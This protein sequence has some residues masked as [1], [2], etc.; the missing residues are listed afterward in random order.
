M[1]KKIAKKIIPK[2]FQEKIYKTL[3]KPFEN[4]A[5]EFYSQEGED[6]ILARFFD[7]SYK[8]FFVDIGAHHPKRFSNTYHFYKKGWRGINI[9]AMP[10]SMKLFNKLRPRDI[11]LE[12]AVS[13]KSQKLT[14]YAFKESALNGFSEE[15]SLLRNK[16]QNCELLFK[17]DLK[18]VALAKVLDQNLPKGQKI[19]F[20]TVDV[21]GLDLE[22]L[23]SNNW[24]K[25]SPDYILIEILN[26][27]LA[28]VGKS[29][30]YK[31]LQPLGYV[32]VAK[33]RDTALFQRKI[34]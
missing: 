2:K 21:E 14:Y 23:K 9:D 1:L 15:L 6:A 11:N 24:K 28:D 26:S 20:M 34:S 18:T 4:F 32:A 19:D 22:V 33:T 3:T 27:N 25:Y 8:G 7:S 29:E 17:K 5:S 10:G 12:V 31:F 13:D 30:V 16:K